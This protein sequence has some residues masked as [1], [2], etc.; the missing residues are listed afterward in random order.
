MEVHHE[1]GPGLLE[2][3]YEICLCHELVSRGLKVQRQLKLP[4]TYKGNKLEAGYRIDLLV[5]ENTIVEIKAVEK[6]D[7]IHEAQLFSYLKLSGVEVGRLLNF[8]T[9]CLKIKSNGSLFRANSR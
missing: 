8:N 5:E 1:L 3:T 6:L 4:V 7:R 9:R 2:S